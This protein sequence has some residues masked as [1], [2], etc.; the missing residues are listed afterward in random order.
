MQ[1]ITSVIGNCFVAATCMC[2]RRDQSRWRCEQLPSA[3][4]SALCCCVVAVL[5]DVWAP[6]DD[7]DDDAMD[8]DRG[9]QLLRG[10]AAR[11]GG[12]CAGLS[13]KC[14]RLEQ[15]TAVMCTAAYTAKSCNQE[16]LFIY[17]NKHLN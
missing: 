6:E 5:Q 2:V 3:A 17:L 4:V 8:A 11:Q 14:P 12:W 16:M 10:M 7:S 15:G 1:D 13:S 9:M